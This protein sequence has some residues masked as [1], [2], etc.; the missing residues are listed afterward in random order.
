MKL[1]SYRDSAFIRIPQK[2]KNPYKI[3][4]IYK[5]NKAEIF[6]LP[7]IPLAKIFHVKKY[8]RILFELQKK[9]DYQFD[10]NKYWKLINIKK[11]SIW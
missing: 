10:Q 9:L 2:G 1:K 7:L 3:K 5:A 8:C 6:E 11:G 4:T